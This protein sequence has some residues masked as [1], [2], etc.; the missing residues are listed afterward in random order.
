[1]KVIIAGSRNFND[2]KKLCKICD[3]LLQNQANV[4]IVS[5][6]A[7]G[8]DQLGEKYTK[9]RGYKLTK[10]PANWNKYG[11]SAGPKRN[12]EMANYADVLIAFWDG[13]SR[14][15]KNMIE[16]ANKRKLNVLICYYQFNRVFKLKILKKTLR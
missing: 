9:E 10:F 1:M 15:T 14:G 13:K 12:E 11:K 6:A 16:L 3:H 7:R 2:Y 5:G 4:E 8:A